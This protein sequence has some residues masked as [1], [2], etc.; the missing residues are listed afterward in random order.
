[1]LSPKSPLW[2]KDH[3]ELKV[4]EKIQTIEKFRAGDVA[5]VVVEQV[6]VQSLVSYTHTHTHKF[7]ALL[8]A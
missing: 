7:S 3:F 1:M 2:L 4:I 6:Q 8:F 5:Q